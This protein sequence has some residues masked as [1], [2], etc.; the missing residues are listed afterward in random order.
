MFY[1]VDTKTGKRHSLH[2]CIEDEARQIIDA[3]NQALRQPAINLQIAQAYLQ[4]GDPAMAARTWQ[5]VM[6]QVH[7]TKTGNTRERWR[8]AIQDEAFDL[9]R[10]RKL[11]ET[12]S[13]HF[14]DVLNKGSVSTNVYLR[15]AHNFAIGMHWLP[16]P[17]LPK[18]HWPPVKYKDKR[19][20]TFE[21]HQKI[22]NRE[23]NPVTRAYFQLL[24]H[25]GGS[26]TDVA[27]LRA[28]DVDWDD[29]TIAYQRCKTGV[30]SLISF[31]NEVAAILKQ[32]PA[33]GQL[34][35]ALARI[36][37]RHRSKLFIKRLRRLASAAYHFTLIV[38]LGRSAR[39]VL[40][41]PNACHAKFG[42][43]QQ[44]SSSRLFKE[45]TSQNTAVGG[46]RT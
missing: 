38:T 12:S 30:T 22:I 29:R 6:E 15:R 25:L 11:I 3:K 42:A 41:I 10:H 35:P 13:E 19:A 20:I 9:L 31:G 40:V 28:E 5:H 14:L 27:M 2:T 43:R 45:G 33:S 24:W 16:W 17:V 39:N 7:S 1:C 26:Q 23:H 21:E 46:I 37:E 4:H 36:H 44:G 8:Y 34:F 32:L 18:L